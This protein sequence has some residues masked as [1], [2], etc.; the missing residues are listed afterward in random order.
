MTRFAL[1][2]FAL[3]TSACAAEGDMNFDDSTDEY[4][5]SMEDIDA[6]GDRT[7]NL[8]QRIVRSTVHE[9]SK[10][11][12]EYGCQIQSVVYGAWS[13]KTQS[14][15]GQVIALQGESVA[16]VGGVIREGIKGMGLI[17]GKSTPSQAVAGEYFGEYVFK[18][19][20]DGQTIEADFHALENGPDYEMFAHWKTKG[21]FNH[22]RGVLARCQ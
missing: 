18:G 1:L 3:F 9:Y 19:L 14:F 11:M 6:N 15:R 4:R 12:D 10:L 2:T 17:A 22:V 20:M 13:T 16:R 8:N 21:R 7:A 5:A